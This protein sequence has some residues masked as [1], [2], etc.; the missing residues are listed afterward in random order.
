MKGAPS[1]LRNSTV[2]YMVGVWCCVGGRPKETSVGKGTR[3]IK[4]AATMRNDEGARGR[5]SACHVLLTPGT[6][7]I[8]QKKSTPQFR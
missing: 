3:G 2:V 7:L 5:G 8:A 6:E 1:L 4:L